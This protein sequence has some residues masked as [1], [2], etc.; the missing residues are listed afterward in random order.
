[1]LI[2]KNTTG[3]EQ[4]RVNTF[5]LSTGA[6]IIG[7]VTDVTDT[8]V[9]VRKPLTL[10]ANGQGGFGLAPATLLGDSEGTITY[11]RSHIVAWVATR[12]EAEKGYQQYATGIAIAGAGTPTGA[13]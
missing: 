12:D 8:T 7:E 1:M 4:G 3:P 10:G 11:Q 6:E 13:K 2:T 5:M 9:T